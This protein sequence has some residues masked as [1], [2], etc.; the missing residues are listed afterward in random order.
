MTIL[1]LL[2][3]ST[4][5]D[6]AVEEDDDIVQQPGYVPA[7]EQLYQ[8]LWDHRETICAL[9]NRPLNCTMMIMENEG[10]PRIMQKDNT[11]TC[12]ESYVSDMLTVHDTCFLSK[13]NAAHDDED[14][15]G[16]LAVKMLL[17]GLSHH[18][19]DRERRHGPFL[20]QL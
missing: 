3:G 19:I 16:Q 4:T 14:C 5:Y 2:R 18:F 13:P 10:M 8:S 12:T 7:T 11:Y 15:R 20:L 9:T 17:R 1:P 6:D